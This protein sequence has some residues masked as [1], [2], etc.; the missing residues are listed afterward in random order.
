MI[1]VLLI[2][3]TFL[4]IS[5]DA[6]GAGTAVSTRV[7]KKGGGKRLVTVAERAIKRVADKSE[8]ILLAMQTVYETVQYWRGKRSTKEFIVNTGVNAFKAAGLGGFAAG[9]FVGN[10]ILPGVGGFIGGVIGGAFT[11]LVTGSVL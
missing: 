4:S 10:A 2:I 6:S 7:A 5:C 11:S 8:I 3:L 9:A 1:L